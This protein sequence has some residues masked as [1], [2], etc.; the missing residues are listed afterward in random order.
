MLPLQLDKIKFPPRTTDEEKII[1]ARTRGFSTRQIRDAFHFGNTKI[2]E[3]IKEYKRTGVVQKPKQNHKPTKLTHEVLLKIHT[4]IYNDAHATLETMQ[5][6][7]SQQFNMAISIASIENGCKKLHYCY[8][9]PQ[10]THLLT[11]KQKADRVSFAYTLI[12]SYYSNEIDLTTNVF[13]DESRFVLGDDRRWVWRR[14]GERNETAT[15]ATL[16]FH[17]AI[18]IYGAISKNYK[19]KLVI[20]DGNIDSTK[21]QENIRK[22]EMIEDMNDKYGRGKWIFMQDGDRCHTSV[23]TMIWLS[24]RCRDIAK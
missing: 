9:H 23:D 8:R 11:P 14:Y 15:T 24:S 7:I 13:S 10:H 21:Y 2:S 16:K 6:T 3:V 18:M 22:S 20:V 17:D 19:S 4:M 12:N 1:F 5:S